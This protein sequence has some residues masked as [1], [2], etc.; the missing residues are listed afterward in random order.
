MPH[1]NIIDGAA[2]VLCAIPLAFAI[3]AAYL[4]RVSR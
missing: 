1:V 4:I 3:L 2:L